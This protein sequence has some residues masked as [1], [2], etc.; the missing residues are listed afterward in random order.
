MDWLRAIDAYCERVDASLLAEPA[1]AL[2][3]GAFLLAALAVAR[4]RPPARE[5]PWEQRGQ[6][7]LIVAVGLGS[8]AFHTLANAWTSLLDT[9]FIALYICVWLAS[10][11]ARIIGWQSRAVA[12][13]LIAYLILGWLLGSVL[14]HSGIGALMQGSGAYLPALL[15]LSL[16][17][18]SISTRAPA[19]ARRLGLAAIV[20]SASLVARTLDLSLCPQWPLGTHFLWHVL[21]AWVLYLTSTALWHPAAESTG[22]VDRQSA[23][24]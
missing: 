7:A 10:F 16:A 1:N 6:P 9:V 24:R 23:R 8:L 5:L 14:S 2:T 12:G 3:N 13:A 19:L 11:M 18:W 20:F 22:Q 21:N 17:A 4:I 15:A